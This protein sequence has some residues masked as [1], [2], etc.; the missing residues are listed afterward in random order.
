MLITSQRFLALFLTQFLGAFN[1]NLLKN[2]LVM[3]I[4]YRLAILNNEN[5]QL[6]VTIA[7]GLFIL[8]FFLFSAT[9]GQLADKYERSRIVRIVKLAEILIMLFAAIG[10]LL[11]SPWLLMI[12]LFFSG[13][14]STFF[15]PIKYALLP[16]HLRTNELLTGNAYIEA[17]TFLAILLGTICGGLII[18]QQHGIYLV[19]CGLLA[20]AIL[21]YISSCYIPIAPAPDPKLKIN[22]NF[23]I[24]TMRIIKYSR[25]T[26]DVFN[27][28][29]GISW[30]WFIGAIFLSQ[31]PV[32]I[33]H[34]LH[35][36]AS[37][38]T[39]FMTLFS[40]GVGLGS[41]ISSRLLNGAIKSTYVPIAAVG[42]TV[43][44]IDLYFAS[45][46]QVYFNLPA[47]LSF[48]SFVHLKDSWR[49]M[50]DV[51]CIAISAGIYIVPL[52]AIMQNKSD[53]TYLARII[54]A[55]NVFNSL[56]IV[57]SVILTLIMFSWSRTIPE[58]FLVVG[59]MN[60]VVAFWIRWLHL[61]R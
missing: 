22:Y 8:P 29:L 47:L 20:L 55:N 46:S 6:L 58:I 28:I 45:L 57:T 26:K 54:A 3:L 32:Y 60:L 37:V 21:G 40:L 34:Q 5:T 53:K 2:A 19:C 10:F 23:L 7:M 41:F 59:L 30:F 48:E 24:D 36:E 44:I 35:A 43:F 25:K 51:I 4:T 15:G 52:Y 16:Q 14:H 42:V 13:V 12:S 31:F 50:L 27:C 49:L 9:A 33:K 17:G 1:D 61:D 11:Q 56:F 18:M 39:L 38:V